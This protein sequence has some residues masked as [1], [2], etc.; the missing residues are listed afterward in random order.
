MHEGRG[1]R[2]TKTPRERSKVGAK[3]R[4]ENEQNSPPSRTPTVTQIVCVHVVCACTHPPGF[5]KVLPPELSRAMVELGINQSG[6]QSR[7]RAFMRPHP[8]HPKE[9]KKMPPRH[10]V[11]PPDQELLCKTHGMQRAIAGSG[12]GREP[13]TDRRAQPAGKRLR[14]SR[15]KARGETNGRGRRLSYLLRAGALAASSSAC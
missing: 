12:A 13:G 2:R 3:V 14:K 7:E 5:H 4:T 10:S 8:C 1:W 11:V 9:K 6:Y 15:R